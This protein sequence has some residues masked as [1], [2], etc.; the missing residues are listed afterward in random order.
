MNS[1]VAGIHLSYKDLLPLA[2]LILGLDNSLL[3]MT[4]LSMVDVSLYPW[5]PASRCVS[6]PSCDH[7]KCLQTLPD[8]P[9]GL[10]SLPFKN[11]YYQMRCAH[12]RFYTGDFI[13]FGVL[14]AF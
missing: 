6:L 5:P 10:K 12:A 3:H 7:Q 14:V 11:L 1:Y 9:W 13:L 4:S 8:V 2:P